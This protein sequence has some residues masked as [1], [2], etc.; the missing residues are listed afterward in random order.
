MCNFKIDSSIMLN[1]LVK[2]IEEIIMTT[3]IILMVIVVSL[4]VIELGW[5]LLK[6]IISPPVFLLEVNELLEVFGIFLLVLIGIEL[7]E[8]LKV[9]ISKKE[10]RAEIILLVA[11][12]AIARK[13]I[14]LDLKS[15]PGDSMLGIAAITLSLTAGYYVLKKLHSQ[16]E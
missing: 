13:V 16:N 6:D 3:L 9:Y 5:I 7:L 14:T 12:I 4:S 2:R 11:I 15:L 1:R 8:T 10:L